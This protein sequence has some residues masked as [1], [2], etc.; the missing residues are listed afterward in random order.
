[1]SNLKRSVFILPIILS[2]IFI[3][4]CSFSNIQTSTQL[5][6]N[7]PVLVQPPSSKS[8]T[9][10]LVEF[11]GFVQPPHGM[12]KEDFNKELLLIQKSQDNEAFRDLAITIAGLGEK[13]PIIDA[14]LR[15][16]IQKS[17][18]MPFA[19]YHHQMVAATALDRF[20]TTMPVNVDIQKQIEFYLNIL[21]RYNNHNEVIVLAKALP[22]LEGYWASPQIEKIATSCYKSFNSQIPPSAYINRGVAARTESIAKKFPEKYTTNAAVASL[23]KEIR[24]NI[25]SEKVI[26]VSKRKEPIQYHPLDSIQDLSKALDESRLIIALLTQYMDI[27]ADSQ[28]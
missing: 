26:A 13:W 18:N 15:N 5:S 7:D 20:L 17:Q 14:Q 9:S 1:M 2:T 27:N 3:E 25:W 4:S 10:S 12:T 19:W 28:K 8:I 22:M 11:G 21:L 16:Y 6:A 23:A 24:A